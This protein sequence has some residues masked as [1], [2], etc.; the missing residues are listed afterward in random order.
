MSPTMSARRW[1]SRLALVVA[2]PTLTATATVVI[3][4]ANAS[5]DASDTH[6]V[7]R[8]R[9]PEGSQ[10]VMLYFG[11]AR[12]AWSNRPEMP[13]TIEAIKVGLS[14]RAYANGWSFTAIGVALDWSPRLG[15]KHL[16]KFGEFDELA[17]GNSWVNSLAQK[18]FWGEMAGPASTPEVV[19]VTRDV[20]RLGKGGIEAGYAASEERLLARKVGVFELRKWV[21][22]GLV[23]PAFGR[24]STDSAAAP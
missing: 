20:A 6:Y 16:A 24:G 2:V 12:C 17:T 4:R 7:P 21:A 9:L 18:Y 22:D 3:R 8:P 13:E 10:V 11:K 15:L 14:R 5:R 19:V 23:L 1:I